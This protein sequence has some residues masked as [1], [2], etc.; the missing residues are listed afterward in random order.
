MLIIIRGVSG[1]GKSTILNNLPDDMVLSS[2]KFRKMIWGHDTNMKSSQEAFALLRKVLESRLVK[3]LPTVIDSTALKYKDVK[4]YVQLANKYNVDHLVVSLKC[5]LETSLMNVQKRVSSGGTNVPK[6]VIEKQLASYES[7]KPSFVKYLNFVEFDKLDYVYFLN[8]IKESKR[9]LFINVSIDHDKKVYV[10]GD[11]HGC[12]Q[13]LGELVEKIYSRDPDAEIYSVG[14]IIDRGEDSFKC[15][16]ILI[17]NDIKTVLGNHEKGFLFEKL[18]PNYKCRSEARA[19]T[20]LKFNQLSK[21]NRRK[22]LN[23]MKDLPLAYILWSVDFKPTIITHGGLSKSCVKSILHDHTPF[24]NVYDCI[25]GCDP[26]TFDYNNDTILQVH[27]HRSWNYEGLEN[28]LEKNIVNLDSHC[29]N[30]EYLS[31]VCLN[32]KTFIQVKAK[33]VYWQFKERGN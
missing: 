5:D 2:D 3:K 10:I 11:I 16:D 25:G 7:Q 22:Y 29:Y 19:I 20:H 30:G 33:K 6:S 13:E 24:L 21:V 17:E 8:L 12:Y 31:A 15:I 28:E 23:Y 18:D 14:D 9:K 4:G 32:D 27:G 1:S 26:F